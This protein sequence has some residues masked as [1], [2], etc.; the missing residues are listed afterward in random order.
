MLSLRCGEGK[1]VA[2]QRYRQRSHPSPFDG[3]D[4][5]GAVNP[6]KVR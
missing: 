5:M 1:S 4:N 6:D 3:E 2:L